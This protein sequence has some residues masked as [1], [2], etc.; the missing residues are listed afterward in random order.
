M[1]RAQPLAT[2]ILALAALLGATA[3]SQAASQVQQ[4]GPQPQV[5]AGSAERALLL[6]QAG[7]SLVEARYRWSRCLEGLDRLYGRLLGRSAA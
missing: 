2:M 7:R 6:G 1:N 4:P 3:A 5:A